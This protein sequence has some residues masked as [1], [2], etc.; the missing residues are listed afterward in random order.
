MIHEATWILV[1]IESVLIPTH[2]EKAN[3]N[4]INRDISPWKVALNQP[5]F[6]GIDLNLPLRNSRVM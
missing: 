3:I 1:H 2:R 4:R 5:H 6:P